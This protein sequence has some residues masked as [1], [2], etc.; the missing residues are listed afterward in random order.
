MT[1]SS[2]A[3]VEEP[4][5]SG[6]GSAIS[7]AQEGDQAAFAEIYRTY[8]KRIE[9]LCHHLLGERDAAK[10][11]CGDVFLKLPGSI[12]TYD[13][14]VPFERWLLRVAANRCV[15]LLRRRNLERRWVAKEGNLPDPPSSAASPLTLILTKER[16]A[17][18]DQAM[19]SLA[20]EYRLPLAMRYYAELSYEEIAAEM[21]LEK[22]QVAGRIFRAKHM[23]RESLKEGPR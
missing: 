6:P 23:L 10:D 17:E 5:P 15:D 11:A 8:S 21:G 18:V 20:P 1:F 9:G 14:S 22:S 12:R 16:R 3:L 7:R 2:T 4:V 13:G 19:A